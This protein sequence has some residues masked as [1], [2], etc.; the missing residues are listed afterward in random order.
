MASQ[1]I[2]FCDVGDF[3]GVKSFI[4]SFDVECFD[5]KH[6]IFYSILDEFNF[7]LGKASR[8]GY[9]E[10]VQFLINVELFE[11]KHINLASLTE[12]AANAGHLEIVQFL[13][14]CSIRI[15]RHDICINTARCV[16]AKRGYLHI[17]WFILAIDFNNMKN[18][19]ETAN[20]EDPFEIMRIRA[21]MEVN[22]QIVLT[23]AAEFG[24]L[25]IVRFIV[26]NCATY[27]DCPSFIISLH[28][29]NWGLRNAASG[30]YIEILQYLI[31]Y[32]ATDF[33]G[34]LF[35]AARSGHFDS[36][37][38]LISRGG[39]DFN[40]ALSGAACGGHF[41]IICYLI[42]KGANDFNHALKG[43][44]SSG[45]INIVNYFINIGATDLNNALKE[46]AKRGHL[47]VVKFLIEKGANDLIT[48]LHAACLSNNVEI[49]AFLFF[50][51]V[52]DLD[53]IID[54]CDNNTDWDWSPSG[55][56]EDF[57]EQS[58]ILP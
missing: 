31:D 37:Y 46:A 41:H 45:H 54:F 19:M 27:V 1:L 50:S 2:N 8:R 15:N 35:Q 12:D 29:I 14:N 26:E 47:N 43:A 6:A 36:V 24:H 33:S 55:Y 56:M 7:A 9:L 44:A 34:S 3:T 28:T 13:I 17:V 48:A 11:I 22:L 25:H 18:K 49:V 21:E 16:A 5:D 57:I 38:F 4:E 52:C 53:D 32:G 10:I 40:E 51:G 23:S 58:D 39:T 20:S 30:G 42:E